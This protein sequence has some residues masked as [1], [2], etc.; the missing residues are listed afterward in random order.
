MSSV[1]FL[2][3]AQVQQGKIGDEA[4][5]LLGGAGYPLWSPNNVLVL[6]SDQR[7]ADTA[8]PGANTSGGRRD[9]IMLMRVGGGSNSRLSIARDTVVDIP[10]H[11]R[12][13]INAAFA[14]AARRWRSRPSSSTRASTS[15]TSSS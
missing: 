9:S 3:S 2:F 12:N 1:V 10:G 13:K 14:S 5:A 15:T 11:G 7:T 4:N 6:G 8:E